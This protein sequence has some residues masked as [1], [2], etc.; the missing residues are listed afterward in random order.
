MFIVLVSTC[1]CI[2]FGLGYVLLTTF[3][4]FRCNLRPIPVNCCSAVSSQWPVPSSHPLMLRDRLWAPVSHIPTLCSSRPTRQQ[5]V[6]CSIC[7]T[8][9][10]R[11]VTFALPFLWVTNWATRYLSMLTGSKVIEALEL[12]SSTSWAIT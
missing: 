5:A 2:L 1:V 11:N 10:E 8:A 7:C 12:W 6:L 3:C 4:T 9:L